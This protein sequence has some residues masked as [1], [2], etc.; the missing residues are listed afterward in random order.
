MSI[1]QVSTLFLSKRSDMRKKAR[2]PYSQSLSKGQIRKK[3][4]SNNVSNITGVR[5]ATRS[6]FPL[7]FPSFL[8]KLSTKTRQYSFKAML[9]LF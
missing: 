4:P 5:W 1:W 8:W 9:V 7:I 6:A 2:Q 3:V